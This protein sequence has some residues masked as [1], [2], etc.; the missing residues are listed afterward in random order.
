MVLA[1]AFGGALARPVDPVAPASSWTE[2]IPE[3]DLP[4]LSP[5]SGCRRSP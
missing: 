2:V 3:A 1:T 5:G 4:R